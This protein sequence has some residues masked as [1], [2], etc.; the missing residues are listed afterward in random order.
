MTVG[1]ILPGQGRRCSK[2]EQIG[3]IATPATAASNAYR[4]AM[5]EVDRLP[6]WRD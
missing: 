4:R 6:V 2:G 3:V 5:I 1:I